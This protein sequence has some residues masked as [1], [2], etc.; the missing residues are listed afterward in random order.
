MHDNVPARGVLSGLAMLRVVLA[1]LAFAPAGYGAELDL[2]KLFHESIP[3]SPSI[4]VVYGYADA[5]LEHGRDTYGP[6]KTGMLLSALDRETLSPLETRPPAPV[7]VSQGSRPGQ[8]GKPLVGANAQMDQNLLRL[9]Y[10]LKGLSGEDRY[11]EAADAA[12]KWLL[13]SA[14]SPNVWR[15]KNGTS[16]RYRSVGDQHHPHPGY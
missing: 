9:L 3:S 7:G 11:P 14:Q 12:L 2:N 1:L 15:K 6:Q 16:P 13:R 5:M 4:G 8:A 10:F